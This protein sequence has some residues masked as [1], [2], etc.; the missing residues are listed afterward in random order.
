MRRAYNE[1]RGLGR[2]LDQTRDTSPAFTG[3]PDLATV[4]LTLIRTWSLVR[5]TA[6]PTLDLL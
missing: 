2:G 6:N 4:T 1:E 5:I 3:G